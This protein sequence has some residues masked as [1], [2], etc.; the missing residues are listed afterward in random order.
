MPVGAIGAIA[1]VGGGLLQ[2]GA[3]R[4]AARSQEAAANRQIELQREIY[5]DTTQRFQPF[6]QGGRSGWDAYLFEMGL[7]DRPTF[8]AAADGTGGTQFRGFQATPG[9]QFQM[10]RGMDA[11]QSSAAARG[12]LMSGA[13][14]QASQQFGNDLGNME[15]TNYLNRLAGVGQ[16]GQAAAGNQANAGANFATNAGNALGSIGNAQAAGA[17]GAG[18]AISGGIQNIMGSLG[19]M[20]GFGGGIGG[21][22]G[23][24]GG[25]GGFGGGIPGRY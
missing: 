13:T 22:R 3:A 5:D 23:F 18:N 2:A 21:A 14:M 9:F 6:V 16:S 11:I 8:G 25:G 24:G 15:Y 4:S 17:I 19:Y 20:Q 10:D 12:G 1:S 7:G